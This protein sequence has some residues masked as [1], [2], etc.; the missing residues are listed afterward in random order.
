MARVPCRDTV[1]DEIRG[2]V[3]RLFTDSTIEYFYLTPRRQIHC[4]EVIIFESITDLATLLKWDDSQITSLLTKKYRMN[5]SLYYCVV[6]TIMR[7]ETEVIRPGLLVG[8]SFSGQDNTSSRNKFSVSTSSDLVPAINLPTIVSRSPNS[9]IPNV[10]R[11]RY[12]SKAVQ[13][14][15]VQPSKKRYVPGFVKHD[16]PCVNEALEYQFRAPSNNVQLNGCALT[17]MKETYK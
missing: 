8:R 13:V 7:S 10:F 1:R 2:E 16:F 5:E 12:F 14:K 15:S 3:T 9:C 6:G 17:R 11:G 4:S